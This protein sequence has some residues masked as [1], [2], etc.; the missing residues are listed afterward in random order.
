MYIDENQYIDDSLTSPELNNK[1]IKIVSNPL[2][3]R[4]N[5]R[6][7]AEKEKRYITTSE[8]EFDLPPK[9]VLLSVNKNIRNRKIRT[10]RQVFLNTTSTE[11]GSEKKSSSTS[12]GRKSTSNRPPVL[13]IDVPQEIEKIT[14]FNDLPDDLFTYDEKKHLFPCPV[15]GCTAEFPSLSR[16]KR[17][18][19]IHTGIKKFKCKNKECDRTFNRKDN[20]M[21]HYRSHCSYTKR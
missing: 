16:I 10:N 6:R 17:H 13:K 11:T 4:E 20:M 3:S 8:Q 9:K 19:H 2:N 21:Q 12:S 7:I 1:K 18:Y 15:D 5:F 14:S